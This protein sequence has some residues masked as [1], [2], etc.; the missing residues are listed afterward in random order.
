MFEGK[1]LK[2]VE[3]TA[4]HYK[5]YPQSFFTRAKSSGQLTRPDVV[6]VNKKRFFKRFVLKPRVSKLAVLYRVD[7]ISSFT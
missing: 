2:L 4:L 5:L 6:I 3:S 1:E 7:S